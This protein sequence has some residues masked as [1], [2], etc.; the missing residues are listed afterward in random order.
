MNAAPVRTVVNQ[1][2]AHSIWPPIAPPPR[3]LQEG[4]ADHASVGAPGR[5]RT[6]TDV[7]PPDFESGASTNSATGAHGSRQRVVPTGRRSTVGNHTFRP[8]PPRS[9][10]HHR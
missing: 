3:A 6:R 4:A 10:R 1:R 2:L 9:G 5:T 8:I 7:N